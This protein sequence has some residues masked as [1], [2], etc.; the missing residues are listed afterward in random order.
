MLGQILLAVIVITSVL[1]MTSIVI[2]MFVSDPL[3][4]IYK[5]DP[6]Y[7]NCTKP[8][9]TSSGRGKPKKFSQRPQNSTAIL[10]AGQTDNRVP[11]L[12]EQYDPTATFIAQA[13]EFLK[14]DDI[15][16][17]DILDIDDDLLD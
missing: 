17:D 11:K 2:S 6:R 9:Q 1:G 12:R 15:S 3:P 14:D 10:Y 4:V 8:Q 7:T 16:S 5:S 13:T